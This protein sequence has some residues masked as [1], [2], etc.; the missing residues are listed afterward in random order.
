MT[1]CLALIIL[2]KSASLNILTLTQFKIRLFQNSR[3]RR[4]KTA[5][6]SLSNRTE[7]ANPELHLYCVHH[8]KFALSW[9]ES[10]HKQNL[11]RDKLST[12]DSDICCFH[13]FLPLWIFKVITWSKYVKIFG[14]NLW[15][16]GPLN[17]WVIVTLCVSYFPPHPLM[18][19]TLTG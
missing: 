3:R 9:L 6:H 1:R 5:L 2:M 11:P 17:Y 12:S 14:T 15:N 10:C 8:F 16:M 4:D 7:T 13:V 18:D 19:S